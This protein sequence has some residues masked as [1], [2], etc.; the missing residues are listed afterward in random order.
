VFAITTSVATNT[1]RQ[2]S[3]QWRKTGPNNDDGRGKFVSR[4]ISNAH[5]ALRACALYDKVVFLGAALGLRKRGPGTIRDEAA[6]F[7]FLMESTLHQMA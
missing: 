2:C 1:P 4:G 5:G 6:R 7:S 3:I